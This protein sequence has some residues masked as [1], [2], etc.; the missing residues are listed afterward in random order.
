MANKPGKPKKDTSPKLTVCEDTVVA[1]QTE[2]NCLKNKCEQYEKLIQTYK[3]AQ[4]EAT[5]LLNKATLEYKARTEYM[6][7]CVKHAYISI[8]FS[9]NASEK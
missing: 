5:N 9:L 2:I 3:Q 8:Q 4:E 7:D 6:L 1:L